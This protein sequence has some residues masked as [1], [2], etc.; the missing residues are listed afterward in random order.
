MEAGL[1]I[2]QCLI[3]GLGLQSQSTNNPFFALFL[4]DIRYEQCQM[5]MAGRASFAKTPCWVV[6]QIL[7]EVEGTSQHS[8]TLQAECELKLTCI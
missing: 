7:G 3:N 4:D 1:F 5:R 8:A 6:L 2:L